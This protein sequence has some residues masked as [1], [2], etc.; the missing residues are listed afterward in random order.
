MA[1][2]EAK[3]VVEYLQKTMKLKVC[4]LTGDNIFSALSVARYLG[5]PQDLVT[6]SAYPAK[7]RKIVKKL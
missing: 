1:K 7:K 2:P 4:M 6:A 3:K 5:I